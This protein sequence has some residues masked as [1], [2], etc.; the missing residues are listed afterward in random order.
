MWGKVQ[1]IVRGL[2]LEVIGGL[3]MWLGCNLSIRM[4]LLCAF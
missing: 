4:R 3:R 2:R 1:E